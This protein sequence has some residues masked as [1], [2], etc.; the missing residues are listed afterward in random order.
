[1]DTFSQKYINFFFV[2]QGLKL[3]GSTLMNGFSYFVIIISIIV[4]K[5][6][7]HH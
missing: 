1:M 4:T 7:Y 3:M 5:V 6:P 2:K